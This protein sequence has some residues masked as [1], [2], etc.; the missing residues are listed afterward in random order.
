MGKRQLCPEIPDELARYSLFQANMSESEASSTSF[1]DFASEMRVLITEAEREI[2]EKKSAALSSGPDF[3]EILRPFVSGIEAIGRATEEHSGRLRRMEEAMV[4]QGNL[5]EVL[6][7]VKDSMHQKNYLNQQLFDALHDELKGYK[8][9]FLLE[10]MQKPIILDL[11]SL[12]DHIEEV[13]RQF[14]TFATQNDSLKQS[15]I[16]S[17]AATLSTNLQ[18]T[19]VLLVEILE[20]MEVFKLNPST[21]DRLDK[22]LHRVVK[23]ELADAVEQDGQIANSLRAGFMWKGRILRPE[24]V[25]MKKFRN[26]HLTMCAEICAQS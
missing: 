8:D 13:S 17:R 26:E 10:V 1:A 16:S 2:Y 3:V 5:R 18:H 15:E 11:I 24:A 6:A 9:G 23:V 19:L 4:T 21:G 20:R 7:P 25:T 12:H 22:A 14:S